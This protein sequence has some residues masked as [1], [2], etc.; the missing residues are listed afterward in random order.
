[1]ISRRV[2]PSAVQ[3]AKI[4]VIETKV[5][6]AGIEPL[7]FLLREPQGLKVAIG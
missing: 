7:R 5:V 3:R 4:S 2:R 6:N 1:M